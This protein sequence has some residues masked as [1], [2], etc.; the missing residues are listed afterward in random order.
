[1]SKRINELDDAGLLADGDYFVVAQAADGTGKAF[2]APLDDLKAYC[3]GGGGG[4]SG[5][6]EPTVI[7]AASGRAAANSSTSFTVTFGANTTAGSVIFLMVSGYG[8]SNAGIA[9]I[10]GL[11]AI[12]VGLG[13]NPVSNQRIMVFAFVVVTPATVYTINIATPNGGQSCYALELDQLSDF[14]IE[15]FIPYFVTTT[16][17]V[18][19]VG[20]ANRLNYL[21]FE[22][23]TNLNVASSPS[24][25]LTIAYD[26]SN[27]TTNHNSVYLSVGDTALN[28][29]GT[30][31]VGT[32]PTTPVAAM[33][34]LAK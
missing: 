14:K 2:K 24:T 11:P 28:T 3:G 13:S 33:V 1:M 23:D 26:S 16:V 5:W 34:S 6:E 29:L 30:F 22:S 15:P 32:T 21:V 9:T 8:A 7:Q 18:P 4:G 25:G 10:N 17:S 31:T 12:G 27:G 20:D 19:I